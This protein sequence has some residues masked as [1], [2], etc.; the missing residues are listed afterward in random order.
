MDRRSERC[1]IQRQVNC[2]HHILKC[3]ESKNEHLDYFGSRIA[4]INVLRN[5]PVECDCVGINAAAPTAPDLGILASPDILAADKASPDMI[6]ALPD[7]QRHDLVERIESRS[8]LRQLEYM[9]LLN[10][11]TDRYDPITR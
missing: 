11:G 9:K 10:M 5:M 7:T 1:P 6:Y 4:C 3:Q 8:G 2:P